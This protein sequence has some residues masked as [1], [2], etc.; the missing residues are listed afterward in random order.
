MRLLLGLMMAGLLLPA[1]ARGQGVNDPSTPNRNV[2]IT[3][4]PPPNV[5]PATRNIPTRVESP[6]PNNRARPYHGPTTRGS[7]SSR[8]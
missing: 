4:P 2:I 7:G 8:R 3:N 5:A 6:P 1:G